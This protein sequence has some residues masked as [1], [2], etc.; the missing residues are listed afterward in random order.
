M[1]ILFSIDEIN[2]VA[3]KTLLETKNKVILFHGKMGVGKT[4]LIKELTRE[5]G[6]TDATSSPTFSLVNEY[7]SSNGEIIY[8]F[9][10]YRLK[11]ESEA[12]DIGFD[13]YVYSGNRCFI[14][15]PEKIPNLLPDHYTEIYIQLEQ[16]G[17]RKLELINK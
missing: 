2:N 6:V 4:T 3:K 13:E 12:L 11:S 15:W 14:E 9:D 16:D 17:K 10:L 8:H 1:E 5:L 7:K